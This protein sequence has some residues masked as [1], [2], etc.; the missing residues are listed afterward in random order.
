MRPQPI[1]QLA[2]RLN[3]LAMIPVVFRIGDNT[4]WA[5]PGG[6]ESCCVNGTGDMAMDDLVAFA[7]ECRAHS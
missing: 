2:G 1:P 3:G 4:G 7:A 5:V 6:P